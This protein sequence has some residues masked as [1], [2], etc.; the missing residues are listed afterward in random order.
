MKNC[1]ELVEVGVR[2]Y[3]KP[4][5][6]I[7]ISHTNVYGKGKCL[8]WIQCPGPPLQDNDTIVGTGQGN[9]LLGRGNLTKTIGKICQIRPAFRAPLNKI[10]FTGIKFMVFTGK[11]IT[12]IKH[13][14]IG[15][16]T[17]IYFHLRQNYSTI[18]PTDIAR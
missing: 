1:E 4:R 15:V 18:K 2:F 11:R 6:G 17:G 16:T 9:L 7:I 10:G 8:S 5:F 14:G 13:S 12:V 3:G